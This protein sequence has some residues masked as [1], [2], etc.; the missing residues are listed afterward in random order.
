MEPWKKDRKSA[1]EGLTIAGL[2]MFGK[3]IS[4]QEEFPNYM[5][6]YQERPEARAE[7][8]W[9]DRISLDGTWSGNLFDFYTRVIRKLTSD[10]KVTL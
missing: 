1:E 3:M 8:R 6:D 7:A 10:L 5:L 9:V 4:I 2:L